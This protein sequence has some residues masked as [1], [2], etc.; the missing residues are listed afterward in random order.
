MTERRSKDNG[1]LN[2][3]ERLEDMPNPNYKMPP[4]KALQYSDE[5][6]EQANERERE[7]LTAERRRRYGDNF[8]LDDDIEMIRR[9]PRRKGR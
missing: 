8:G 5:S 6:R 9:G 1:P 4:W 3:M 2:D 7:R